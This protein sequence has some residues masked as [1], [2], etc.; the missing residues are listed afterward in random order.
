MFQEQ[1]KFLRKNAEVSQKELS[2]K[3]GIAQS[4]I[5]YYE[6]GKVEPSATSLIKLADFFGV[7]VDYLLGR[8]DDFGNVVI[9][10]KKNS[11]ALTTEEKRL[12]TAYRKLVPNMQTYMLANME[13]LAAQTAN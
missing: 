9:Q 10:D 12:L 4:V 3:T 5:C 6:N 7:S 2:E 8:E 1:L 13:M 11:P